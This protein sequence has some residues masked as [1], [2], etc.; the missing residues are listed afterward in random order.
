MKKS[1]PVRN[2]KLLGIVIELCMLVLYGRIAF[3]LMMVNIR[4]KFSYIN[5]VSRASVDVNFFCKK[6][7]HAI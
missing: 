4:T 2:T 5:Y 7:D 1:H 6:H 3:T